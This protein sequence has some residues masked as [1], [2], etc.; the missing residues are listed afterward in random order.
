[1]HFLPDVWL[2]CDICKGKRYN[3][4]TLAVLYKGKSIADVLE[5]R[6]SDAVALFENQPK[7]RQILQTLDDVGLG[8]MA[9]GQS[10]PTLSGGEAQRVK[11]AAELARPNTGK[12]IYILDEPTTGLHFDDVRKL[13][14][15]LH[16]LVDLGN[17]VVVVE[18]NLDVIKSSDW[19]IDLGPEAGP[20]G[21]L[22]VAQGTPEAIVTAT[23]EKLNPSDMPIKPY[24]LSH[25]AVALLPVLNAG[26]KIERIP[27]NPLKELSAKEKSINIKDLGGDVKMPWE[28]DGKNWHTTNRITLDGKPCRWEGKA[29]EFLDKLLQTKKA[30]APA[31][32][33]ERSV[34]E[35]TATGKPA[36]WFCHA[37]TGH[38]WLLRLVFRVPKNSFNED[39]LNSSLDIPTLN[40]TEGLEIYGNESRVRVGNLKKSPWQQITILV[41]RLSEIQNDEFKSFIDSATAAHLDHIKRL[42]LKPEDLMPWKLHGDKWHLGEKGF[43]IG[44]KLYWDR[45]ILKDI[46]DCAGKS[47]KSLEVQWDNRDCVTF[48]VKGVTHSWMMVKTK[49]N[50][51]LEVRLSGPSGKV[52]L[53]MAKG[54]GFEQELI[55]HR[56]EMDVIVLKFR[57][58]ED[59]TL[60]KLSEFFKEHLGHFI[61]MKSEN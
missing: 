42:S 17:T 3:P 18:H 43:P 49:G 35:F 2:E 57:K 47:G 12:T 7:I 45:N 36:T 58:P 61:K 19:I 59:F 37:L 4:E 26:P 56:N 41:H 30:I 8:Y 38:E 15:V 10:A 60:P 25:T 22:V 11:L 55:E 1:M 20:E 13:L 50:E 31:D 53:D 5:M 32:W 21:G 24:G 27:H 23:W 33:T 14:E 46:L 16:R 54:I 48:R 6:I 44:K 52:N 34:V 28:A 51:F 9:L 39:E 40:N 29:L